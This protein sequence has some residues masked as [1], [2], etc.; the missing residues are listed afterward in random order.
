MNT[1]Y[2]FADRK[3]SKA[4]YHKRSKKGE[5]FTSGSDL[6]DA[7]YLSMDAL[8]S[9]DG[10]FQNGAQA[11]SENY[12]NI[13][14]DSDMVYEAVGQ[15]FFDGQGGGYLVALAINDMPASE[16]SISDGKA[17]IDAVPEPSAL[18]LLCLG[19]GGLLVRR[20]RKAA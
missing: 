12:A 18:A 4:S 3:G 8:Y 14:F 20:N 15:F 1:S 6:S 10:S 5:I 11:G 19:A 17:A 16:L 13:S 2:G 7:G 9:V